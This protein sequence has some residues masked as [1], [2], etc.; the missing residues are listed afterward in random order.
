MSCNVVYSSHHPNVSVFTNKTVYNYIFDFVFP[1]TLDS[2]LV[3]MISIATI[4]EEE[5][6]DDLNWLHLL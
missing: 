2:N 6:V 3:S 4:A 5:T 1:T